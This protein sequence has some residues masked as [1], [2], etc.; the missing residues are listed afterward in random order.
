MWGTVGSGLTPRVQKWL[1]H[2]GFPALISMGG[3]DRFLEDLSP[4]VPRDRY[5]ETVVE[6]KVVQHVKLG[7]FKVF[8]DLQVHL[9]QVQGHRQ[10]GVGLEQGRHQGLIFWAM[11]FQ[12]KLFR[13]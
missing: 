12:Q 6:P 10:P 1:M 8:P 4:D 13:L 2:P 11:L 9:G 5:F 7:L 3:A